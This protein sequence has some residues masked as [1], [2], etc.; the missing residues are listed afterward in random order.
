MH[1][2]GIV[3]A[4]QDKAFRSTVRRTIKR[5]EYSGK[6]TRCLEAYVNIN[7]V[8]AFCLFDTGSTCDTLSPEF[9]KVVKANVADL[10]EPIGLYLGCK[11]NRSKII[12]GTICAVNVGSVS[13]EHYFDI[14]N[15][16]HYDA[17]LGVPFMS[18]HDIRMAPGPRTLTIG[19]SEPVAVISS[20]G[21]RAGHT[22]T[23]R[24]T[25]SKPATQP[26]VK[27]AAAR[28]A[29]GSFRSFRNY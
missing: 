4:P 8:R 19:N 12:Y 13:T 2:D 14:A 27:I 3:G 1:A 17:I 23:V 9:A 21:G 11:G 25:P 26:A 16:D 20:E 29:E 10:A 5:P 6:N 24:K 7:G 28:A 18:I 22:K 15:I